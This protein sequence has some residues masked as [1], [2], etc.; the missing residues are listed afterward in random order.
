[1][2]PPSPPLLVEQQRL[3]LASKHAVSLCDL[4][5]VGPVP[6]WKPVALSATV[7]A[8]CVQVGQLT[9]HNLNL[10]E[11]IDRLITDKTALEELSTALLTEVRAYR[12]QSGDTNWVHAMEPSEGTATTATATTGNG[13]PAAS[14]TEPAPAVGTP[15]HVVR[16]SRPSGA[17]SALSNRSGADSGRDTPFEDPEEVGHG[18]VHFT[19]TCIRTCPL[20]QPDCR[21]HQ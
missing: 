3:L 14:S 18:V 13:S 15:L 8:C 2:F 21:T 4:Y 7:G 11:E 6:V 19:R 9:S 12:V 1:M 20:A 10:S 17:M 5:P 16:I